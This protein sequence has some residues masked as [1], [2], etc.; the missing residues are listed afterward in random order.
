MRYLNDIT[1]STSYGHMNKYA[2]FLNDINSS[3]ITNTD[4]KKK[5]NSID[6]F[7]RNYEINLV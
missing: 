1:I 7:H 2:S 5:L 3:D 6:T 4:D